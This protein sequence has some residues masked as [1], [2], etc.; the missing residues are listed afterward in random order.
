MTND[1]RNF[2][3]VSVVI[4]TR[5][6]AHLLRDCLKGLRIQSYPIDL[7]EIVIVDDGSQ[8]HTPQVA[9]Q[10]ANSGAP[11]IRY[12]RIDR[13]GLNA[14]RNA[15]IRAARGDP[16]CFVDDDDDV[17]PTW[18]EA[19]IKGVLRHPDAGCFGGPIQLRLEAR[20][21]RMCGHE[22][23]GE[24]ELDLGNEECSADAVYGANFSVRRSAL[25]AVGLFDEALP[26][27]GDEEEWERRYKARAGVI[28]YV[29]QA[30]LWHRRLAED[31]RFLPMLRRRFRR[32]RNQT[33]YLRLTGQN[34]PICSELVAF[35]RNVGHAVKRGCPMGVIAAAENVGRI[36]GALKV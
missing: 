19:M 18:L 1:E 7:Y 10:W 28:W 2:P 4:P 3:F 23:L 17:P 35:L 36:W 26:I 13:K 30:W 16:I 14:A 21:P 32:R 8:D 25:H 24:T 34:V 9:A 5:D 15:G 20:P 11:D 27:Y 29:P 31:L 6:R 22:R 33:Q 12:V